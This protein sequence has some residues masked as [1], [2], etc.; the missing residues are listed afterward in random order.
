MRLACVA[1]TPMSMTCPPATTQTRNVLQVLLLVCDISRQEGRNGIEKV[2][3]DEEDA[4]SRRPSL[5]PGTHLDK[6]QLDARN[7]L[8][9]A[10]ADAHPTVTTD[11]DAAQNSER[12]RDEDAMFEDLEAFLELKRLQR[13]NH[14]E[15]MRL[16]KEFEAK[17]AEMD[18]LDTAMDEVMES[19]SPEELLCCHEDLTYEDPQW[20]LWRNLD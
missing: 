3:V 2:C 9:H 6:E 8:L 17:L 15:S 20:Q 18:N 14:R 12:S 5:K 4:S 11:A 16:A 19:I 13:K 1:Q 10:K 7:A